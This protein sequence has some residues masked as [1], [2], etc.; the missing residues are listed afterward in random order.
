VYTKQTGKQSKQDERASLPNMIELAVGMKVIVTFD[1]ETDLD[2]ANDA[3]GEV[4]EI[5]MDEHESNFSSTNAVVEL[6][7]PPAYVL[8]KLKRTKAK[9]LENLDSGILPLVPIQ[10]TFRIIIG[11]HEEVVTRMQ[12]PLTPAYVFTDYRL[13]GQTIV[14]I[15]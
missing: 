6:R 3:R 11:G 4:A 9:V 5:V 15:A 7:Y 1:V 10:R 8:I 14:D 12:L 13:Q 2:V